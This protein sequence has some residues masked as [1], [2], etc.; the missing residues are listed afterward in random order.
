MLRGIIAEHR[1]RAAISATLTGLTDEMA[2]APPHSTVIATSVRRHEQ[3][4]QKL[5][6]G[7]AKSKPADP[8]PAWSLAGNWP[9][10]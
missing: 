1:Y 3:P 9:L 4:L 6:T 8:R 10:K 7:T 2:T 5:M